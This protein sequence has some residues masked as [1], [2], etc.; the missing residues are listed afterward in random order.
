MN[1]FRCG[2]GRSTH[3]ATKITVAKTPL[4]TFESNVSGLNLA[5]TIAYIVATQAG[6]GTPSPTNPRTI[7]GVNSVTVT[8]K[9]DMDTPTETRTATTALPTTCYGGYLNL[10]TGVLT[11]NWGMLDL[12][13]VNWEL[14]TNR[15][16]T[17]SN[18]K[19][20]DRHSESNHRKLPTLRTHQTRN[21][22]TSL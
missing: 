11:L 8:N 22:T 1:Y 5:E 14:T 2:G 17:T 6:S 13:S 7:N 19:P 18:R 12:S 4:A 3:T 20:L 10:E 16:R 9:D 21:G 15:A